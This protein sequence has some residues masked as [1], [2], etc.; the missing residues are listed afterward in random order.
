M[1]GQR[2]SFSELFLKRERRVLEGAGASGL[3]RLTLF[4]SLLLLSLGASLAAYRELKERMTD[5]FT[6]SL[7]LPLTRMEMHDQ[8]RLLDSLRNPGLAYS[9]QLDTV[10]FFQVTFDHVLDHRVG[11]GTDYRS[12]SLSR[13]GKMHDRILSDPAIL[14]WEAGHRDLGEDEACAVLVTE[15][16]VRE[17]GL[18]PGSVRWLPYQFGE[19]SDFTLL[20]PVR[21]VVARLPDKCDMAFSDQLARLRND[22]GPTGWVDV[23]SAT[24]NLQL[25]VPGDD[26]LALRATLDMF[27]QRNRFRLKDMQRFELDRSLTWYSLDFYVGED[28][29]MARRKALRDS[30]AALLPK[31]VSP[32]VTFP[33][34]C[35]VVLDDDRFPIRRHS[36]NLL[37]H[38]MDHVRELEA[39]LARNFEMPLDL[40]KVESARNFSL[41]AGLTLLLS[42]GLFLFSLISLTMYMHF[43]IG[44]H[45]R[46]N[47]SG[48]GTLAAFGLSGAELR[49]LFLKV[50]ALFLLRAVGASIAMSVILSLVFG[51]LPGSI[52]IRILDP[53]LALALLAVFLMVFWTARRTLDRYLSATPG[54][55]IYQRIH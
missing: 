39:W 31:G 15:K 12:R 18:D 10:E 49:R 55:L 8:E 53:V 2:D 6:H 4:L 20:L 43:L 3:I 27:C 29:N 54:D 47:R 37:F 1:S 38:N 11:M 44:N 40:S 25:L 45:I 48:L 34:D 32:L 46:S 19:Q 50:I 9:F 28:L 36:L 41:V 22:P 5:P 35:A 17:A 26:S 21:A 16:L 42:I 33:R 24:R 30:L 14:L 13:E 23:A 52:N 51:M 7:E